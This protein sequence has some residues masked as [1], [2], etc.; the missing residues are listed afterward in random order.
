MKHFKAYTP[1]R[2]N[3]TVL[4][5][6]EITKKTPEKSLLAVKKEKAGLIPQSP[7]RLQENGIVDMN[8]PTVIKIF[9]GFLAVA[10]SLSSLMFYVLPYYH[11]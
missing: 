5:Y 6:S 10:S 3:M 1:S 11:G 2:R 8:R 9:L 4:D 7:P